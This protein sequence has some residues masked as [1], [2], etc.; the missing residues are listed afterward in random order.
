[1]RGARL[2]VGGRRSVAMSPAPARVYLRAPAPR[3]SRRVHRADAGQPLV[4][5]PV[6]DRPDR[7]RAVRRLSRRCAPRRTSR[8]CSCAAA[9]TRRS[10]A[11]STSPRS[12]GAA[13]RAPTWGT[14]SASRSPARATC[15]RASSWCCATPSS[16]LRL[17]RIEANIQPGNASSLALARGRRLPPRGLLAA[18]PED[19]RPLARSRAL[20]DPGRGLARHAPGS[21]RRAEGRARLSQLDWPPIADVAQ[22]VEHFTRNVSVSG[23]GLGGGFPARR[24]ES[25]QMQGVPLDGCLPR[26]GRQNPRIDT[27][28]AQFA[29]PLQH[30]F[31]P[32][33]LRASDTGRGDE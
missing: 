21:G 10:S 4:P 7:R 5:Q 29:A 26:R 14:P 22:L 19:R 1:M 16:T 31:A 18:V 12:S 30:R 15:A 9:R 20:G 3:R 23:L 28:A 6:G 25:P 27:A 33:G 24:Q 8:R 32:H 17:H 2:P 11:S 13:S